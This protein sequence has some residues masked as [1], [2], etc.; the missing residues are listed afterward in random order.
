MNER[1]AY[2]R[3]RNGRDFSFGDLTGSIRDRKGMGCHEVA[4]AFD[5]AFMDVSGLRG[6]FAFVA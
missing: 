6:G 3:I 1:H 5:V 4:E 2:E